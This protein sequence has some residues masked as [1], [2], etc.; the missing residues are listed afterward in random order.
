DYDVLVISG[1]DEESEL[2]IGDLF[3]E[4]YGAA[5]GFLEAF[6]K[7]R[8]AYESEGSGDFSDTLIGFV[9]AYSALE[10][11][12]EELVEKVDRVSESLTEAEEQKNRVAQFAEESEEA[13][14]A[15]QK[16]Q[17]EIAECQVQVT[18]SV[19]K[20][21]DVQGEA[22][23][24]EEMIGDYTDDF[25][26]FQEELDG[27]IDALQE[28]SKKQ[29]QL[30][31]RL[32]EA[33]SNIE[34]MTA[35]A[36]GMLEGAT[37]AGLA[38]AF[39]RLRSDTANDLKTARRT[40]YFAIG[41]LFLS[42]IP[43]M[44]YIFPGLNELFGLAS[45]GVDAAS[46]ADDPSGNGDQMKGAD[47]PASFIELIGQVAVRALLL[48][49]AAWFTKF[50]AAR[51]AALFRLQEHYAYKYSV[52]SSV[53]GFKQQAPD[54]EEEIAAATFFELTFNP[55][56]KMEASDSGDRNPNRAMDWVMEKM[57]ATHDGEASS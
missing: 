24:L 13:L 5:E 50:A 39:E 15:A 45:G 47:T 49:P 32:K 1:G 19:E 26:R 16:G 10:K 11:N 23:R 25:T 7:I 28:G 18:A 55:A 38:G 53:E 30:E 44:T 17:E 21:S 9:E 56:E 29:L 48:L 42:V 52:A 22:E 37:V 27:R 35:R 34:D 51:H 54:Y 6:Q 33:S 40:F 41:F 46:V 57:G 2:R 20:V 8:A 4:I 36:E 12:F 31:D 14:A 3:I 43:L